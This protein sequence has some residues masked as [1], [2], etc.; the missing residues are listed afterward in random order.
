MIKILSNDVI[1]QI[2]AG[3]VV[4]RPASVLK[5]LLE[6]SIDASATEIKVYI[7]AFGTEKIQ[8][9]DNGHGILK[10]D[11]D[12]VFLKHATSKISNINDLDE[13]QTFGFRGE[14]LASIS[15]VSEVIL[16]T[17]HDTE[18]IGTE[19][20]YKNGSIVSQKPCSISKGT[21]IQILNLFENIPARKKFLKSKSTENRILIEIFNKF[22][23]ANP[24]V[25]FHLNIDGTSKTY[26]GEGLD[27]RI[28]KVLKVKVEDLIDV[29]YDGEVKVSGFVIHPRN[30][31]K[32]K[33][34]QYIF[35]NHRTVT[36]STIYKAVVDGF[37][38][39]LMKHQYPGFVLF[40]DLPSHLVDVNVHP[41]KT[42][43]RF[44]NGQDIYKS[45][46]LAVNAG[47]VRKLR[48]EVETKLSIH[49]QNDKPAYSDD[50][51]IKQTISEPH[52]KYDAGVMHTNQNDAVS[53]QEFED[54]LFESTKE[55]IVEVADNELELKSNITQQALEFN[56]EIVDPI[57]NE[58]NEPKLFLNFSNATQLLNSYI[59]ADNGKDILVIDQHA[60][61]E[62]YFYEKYLKQLR[63]KDVLSKVLLFPEVVTLQEYEASILEEH[64]NLFIDLG[65]DFEIFGT[66]EIKITKVPEFVKLDNFSK[67]IHKLIS[68]ILENKELSTIKEKVF[69]ETAAILACHTAVRFGDILGKDEIIK[70]LKDLM[71]CEDPYNCP[72]GRPV[73]QEFSKYDI[74]KRFKRCGL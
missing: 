61:S 56:K 15:S 9:I 58:Q 51:E 74:E 48:K 36:D 57:E 50:S 42:E 1:N 13:I 73:M 40:V 23:L 30:F 45:V 41:R 11:I 19:V 6:N 32:N 20:I 4:E 21:D 68:D 62:R 70:I 5:E 66:D 43:V 25:T 7:S 3:E 28:S 55:S 24:K 53:V 2:A 69:H 16:Q 44:R 71:T 60:A 31:L 72:H 14:A 37:D 47:L 65:F 39:F 52:I 27:G 22:S 12:R 33:S 17:K 26:Q 64:K 38:T 49:L 63:S 35:V 8:I 67:L 59:L 10:E 29:Y 18:E 46:R 34:S 54:F